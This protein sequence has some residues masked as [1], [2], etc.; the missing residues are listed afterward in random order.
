MLRKLH[1]RSQSNVSTSSSTF[2]F[3]KKLSHRE[4]RTSKLWVTVTSKAQTLFSGSN[5]GSVLSSSGSCAS[6]KPTA[7]RIKPVTRLAYAYSDI[8]FAR[9][10]RFTSSRC[11]P[12][13][14]GI[15]D[16]DDIE[17]N[18]TTIPVLVTS[19]RPDEPT[20]TRLVYRRVSATRFYLTRARKLK[21][22]NSISLSNPEMVLQ[23]DYDSPHGAAHMPRAVGIIIK[24]MTG[25]QPLLPVKSAEKPTPIKKSK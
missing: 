21:K 5:R 9:N 16:E 17:P 24:P 18:S 15:R 7:T 14:E 8:H 10:T 25:N 1:Q 20:S 3:Q 6:I 19:E 13:S 22:T 2:S 12:V 11:S 4:K 23:V